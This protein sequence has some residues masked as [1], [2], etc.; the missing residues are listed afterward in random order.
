MVGL[1]PSQSIYHKQVEDHKKLEFCVEKLDLFKF[2]M[3][4]EKKMNFNKLTSKMSLN[5]KTD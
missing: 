5:T 3:W 1:S 2:D 4:K